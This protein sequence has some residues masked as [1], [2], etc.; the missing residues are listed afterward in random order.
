MLIVGVDGPEVEVDY[1]LDRVAGLMKTSGASSMRVS[2]R[3][4]QSVF[5]Q[6]ENRLS[7]RWE[8]YL[9]PDIYVWTGLSRAREAL[10]EMLTRMSAMSQ[11]YGLRVANVFHAGDGN[12]PVNPV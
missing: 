5:G 8:T 2:R 6:G 11:K 4:A 12:L 1:L 3:R 10:P 7:L 9:A